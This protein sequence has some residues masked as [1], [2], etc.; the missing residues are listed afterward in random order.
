MAATK[1]GNDWPRN[2]RPRVSCAH[3]VPVPATPRNSPI[4]KNPPHLPQAEKS[5]SG[6]PK[7]K[8]FHVYLVILIK[9]CLH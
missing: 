4:R 8:K 2:V 6:T 5:V 9:T 1:A 7:M 3:G